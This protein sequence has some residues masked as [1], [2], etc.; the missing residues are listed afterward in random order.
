MKPFDLEAAKAGAPPTTRE[1]AI[2]SYYAPTP[3]PSERRQRKQRVEAILQE[4]ARYAG[5]GNA[6]SRERAARLLTQ[7]NAI[8]RGVEIPKYAL[9]R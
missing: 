4:S 8:R 6:S 7:A 2:P 1:T 3:T 5:R 9:V